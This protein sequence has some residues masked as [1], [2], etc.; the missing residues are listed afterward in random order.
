MPA[1]SLAC[2]CESIRPGVRNL[3]RPSTLRV[4]AL[5]AT[6]CWPTETM[7]PSRISTL[8]SASGCDCSGEMTVTCSMSRSAAGVA[9]V[10]NASSANRQTCFMFRSLDECA[11]MTVELRLGSCVFG[12]KALDQRAHRQDLVNVG[13]A[14]AAAPD[15]APRFALGVAAAAEVHLA[16]VCD[17]Q[18]VR[19]EPGVD[20]ARAQVVAVHAREQVRVHDV[21]GLAVDQR[22]FVLRACVCF[23]GC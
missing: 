20:D 11:G 19:I 17:R 10:A 15:V 9:K 8:R 18:R 22:L 3:P 1:E 12:C 2:T 14:L 7:R 16:L 23:V 5:A 4:S 13:D 21:L 6:A